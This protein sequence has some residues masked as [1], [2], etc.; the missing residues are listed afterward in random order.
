MRSNKIV[1]SGN[2]IPGLTAQKTQQYIIEKDRYEQR[3]NQ[4][5]DG[6]YRRYIIS[7]IQ[8]NIEQG[9]TMDEA[10]EIALKDDVAKKF[11]YLKKNGLDI[12]QCF[13]NWAEAYIKNRKKPY[14]NFEIER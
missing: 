10:I 7:L 1:T 4:Q 9:K 11:E 6:D 2:F 3:K 5:T 12:K 14:R 8:K 13:K